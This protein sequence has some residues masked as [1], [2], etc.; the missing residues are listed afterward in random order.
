MA[1][2][3]GVYAGIEQSAARPEATAAVLKA[4]RRTAAAEDFCVHIAQM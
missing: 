2:P 1:L 4:L 3:G